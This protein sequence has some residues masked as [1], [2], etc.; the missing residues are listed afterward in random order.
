MKEHIPTLVHLYLSQVSSGGE[1]EVIDMADEGIRLMQDFP[2][3]HNYSQF[4]RIMQDLIETA[5]LPIISEAEV[6][7]ALAREDLVPATR[8][9]VN[10]AE[11]FDM[12]RTLD[13]MNQDIV[14]RVLTDCDGNQ[15]LAAKRLGISRTTMWRYVNK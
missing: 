4:K 11:V 7:A 8:Q 15:T 1:S 10:G 3:E 5:A 6:R 2:W 9:G 14:R 13:E 12:N